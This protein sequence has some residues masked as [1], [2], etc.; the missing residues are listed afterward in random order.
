M[1]YK[2]FYQCPNCELGYGSS[3]IS[4]D[5]PKTLRH[6]TFQTSCNNCN[7]ITRMEWRRSTGVLDCNAGK[8]S[9]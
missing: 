7:N 1:N 8:D 2:H 5:K 4:D 9:D 3:F 6:S